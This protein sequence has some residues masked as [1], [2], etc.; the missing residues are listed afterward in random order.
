VDTLAI[1][2]GF[3][4][5][6]LLVAGPVYQAVLE[7]RAE[8]IE[9]DRLRRAAH[10]VTPPSPVS[11]WWWLLPPV[12][13]VLE[14]R[15]RERHQDL[16]VSHLSDED[17]EALRSFI[18]KATGWLLVGSG[19]LLIAAKETFELVEHEEWPT[20]AFWVLVVA[21]TGLAVGHASAR[22]AHDE[23][24]ARRRTAT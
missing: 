17:Y 2:C 5:A 19:G 24:T 22:E 11:P 7:L 10:E 6:W 13:L 23:R 4:G 15:R 9:S 18:N 8:R 20:A 21:M 3:L 16:V 1:W 12:K 14:R